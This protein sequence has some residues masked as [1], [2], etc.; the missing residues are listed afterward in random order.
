MD[1]RLYLSDIITEKGMIS[2]HLD[3]EYAGI[4]GIAE[5]IGYKIIFFRRDSASLLDAVRI[6]DIT[7]SEEVAFS[8]M[9]LEKMDFPVKLGDTLQ[10]IYQEFGKETSQSH[11]LTD[12]DRYHY[13]MPDG[14]LL[15]FDISKQNRLVT[16]VEMIH[17]RDI[18]ENIVKTLDDS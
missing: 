16:G 9:I 2:V 1:R 7:D 15:T 17:N 10:R 18:I 8:N 6:W 12:C 3:F 11:F 13:T 14:F 5:L 4:M